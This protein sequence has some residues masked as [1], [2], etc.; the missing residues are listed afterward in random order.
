MLALG[1]VLGYKTDRKEEVDRRIDAAI[2]QRRELIGSGYPS[3]RPAIALA[4]QLVARRLG[5]VSVRP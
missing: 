4:R 1:G 3:Q 5:H 2:S